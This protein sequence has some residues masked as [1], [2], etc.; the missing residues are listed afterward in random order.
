MIKTLF[1]ALFLS[2]SLAVAEPASLH[3]DIDIPNMA[4]VKE[5]MRQYYKSGR[6]LGE[7]DTIAEQA[8]SYLEVNLPR[9]QDRRP[10]VVLDIDETTLSNYP[11]IDAFDFGYIPK[12]WSAWILQG[13]APALKGPLGFFRYAR[14]HDVAVFFITGRTEKERQATERNLRREGYDGWTELIMKADGDHTLTGAYKARH[15]KQLTEQGYNIVVNLGDQAS[16]LEGGYSEAVFK[17]P[18]PM[19]YV[20]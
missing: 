3:G 9:V 2:V 20:P 19:Y 17:L 6:Y 12:E 16:D 18:N 7:V 15:R 5:K 14:Q 13:E 10:A 8:R 4:L 11:H 1:C